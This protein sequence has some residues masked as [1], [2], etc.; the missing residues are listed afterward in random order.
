MPGNESP[1][2]DR[3]IGVA[4]GSIETADRMGKTLSI[5]PGLSAVSA[6]S[7]RKGDPGP[8]VDVP[9]N[10]LTEGWRDP[11]TTR[12][13]SWVRGTPLALPWLLSEWNDLTDDTEDRRDACVSFL[14]GW[15]VAIAHKSPGDG[16]WMLLLNPFGSSVFWGA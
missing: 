2:S 4:M 3:G 13:R 8:P 6:C 14:G 5:D 1:P 9:G 15:S 12:G 16:G 7:E 10:M 11:P